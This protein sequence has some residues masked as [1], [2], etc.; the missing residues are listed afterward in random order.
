VP[1]FAAEQFLA[2]ARV[3]ERDRFADDAA[4][5]L[6]DRRDRPCPT[7]RPSC[8]WVAASGVS[9]TGAGVAAAAEPRSVDTTMNCFDAAFSCTLRFRSH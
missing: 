2:F 8:A 5:G 6:A 7:S 9:G 4:L 3:G 1:C